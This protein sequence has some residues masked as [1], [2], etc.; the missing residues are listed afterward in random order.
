MEPLKQGTQTAHRRRKN[1]SCI[2]GNPNRETQM[3]HP[4]NK[5]GKEVIET[6]IQ[7]DSTYVPERPAQY[8]VRDA[9]LTGQGG[10]FG[11]PAFFQKNTTN[12]RGGAA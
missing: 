9:G 2:N 12:T 11:L 8:F 4:W 7:R 6:P 3:D 10:S 1:A 5:K